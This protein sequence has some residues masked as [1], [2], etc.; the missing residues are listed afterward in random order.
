MKNNLLSNYYR[1]QSCIMLLIVT[2]STFAQHTKGWGAVG[3]VYLNLPY[4]NYIA[5]HSWGFGKCF[6]VGDG[7]NIRIF[8]R[9]IWESGIA[10]F[11]GM[12]WQNSLLAIL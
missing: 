11:C 12:I 10:R 7:M 6:S 8:I 1:L 5:E 4:G 9:E 2:R 3:S